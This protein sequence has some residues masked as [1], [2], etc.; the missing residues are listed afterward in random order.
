MRLTILAAIAAISLPMAA[1]AQGNDQTLAD[2]RQELSVL[3]VELQ[4]LKRELSTTGGAQTIAPSS[5]VLDRVNVI[6]SELQRLTAK[7]EELEFRIDSVVRDGTN[8]IGDI[9][10][11]LC[12]I[13][14][15]CDLASLPETPVLGGGDAPV[16]PRPTPPASNGAQM[17]VGEQADFDRAKGELD[18]GSFESASSLFAAFTETYPAGPL[19]APAHFHQGDALTE[20]GQSSEAA[21]AYLNAF[22]ADP[23]GAQAPMSLLRLGQSLGRL[24]QLNE[25]CIT[26]GEVGTRFPGGEPAAEA[27]ASRASL[28][29][30]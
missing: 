17:A 8:R 25:A 13:E 22:S 4:T 1:P 12:E 21:R 27:E 23:N 10:F 20:M 15:G 26:L 16:A 6:E 2:I 30:S 14:P 7:S 28:G 5:S 11:R 19:T 9:Q 24:G 3:F 18:N 29:C